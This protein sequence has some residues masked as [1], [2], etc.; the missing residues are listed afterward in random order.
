MSL[1]DTAKHY[2]HA[3]QTGD[4]AA[5]GRLIAPDVVWHQPGSN[6]FSGPRR[7]VSEVVEM[8]GGMMAASGGSFRIERANRYMANG[9]WVTIEIEFAAEREGMTMAQAGIDLLRIE[10][11]QIVEARLFSSDQLQEDRFWG[12][13]TAV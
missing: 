5:L 13:K 7:G 12:E 3:V 10:H 11:G 2:I 8:I 9:S 1:I 4:Q 6:R